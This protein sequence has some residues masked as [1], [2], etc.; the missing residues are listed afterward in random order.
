MRLKGVDY[1]RPFFYMVTLKRRPGLADFSKISGE[2]EPPRD[3]QGKPCF[4]VA[5]GIT[6]AF[7]NQKAWLPLRV[8]RR[9]RLAGNL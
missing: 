9:L 5:N 6:R 7:G 8:P 3:A 2:A 4:L 1:R